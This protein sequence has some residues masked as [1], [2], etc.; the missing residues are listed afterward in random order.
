MDGHTVKL[1]QIWPF[2]SMPLP[3]I[4]SGFLPDE[5]VAAITA[6]IR[7]ARRE[8]AMSQREFAE[9]CLIPERTY[10]RMEAGK[11]DSLINLVKVICYLDRQASFNLSFI[12]TRPSIGPKTAPEKAKALETKPKRSRPYP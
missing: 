4:N 6:R 7:Q 1:G 10:K 9:A 5:V 2:Y 8:K 12:T 3:D 11:C